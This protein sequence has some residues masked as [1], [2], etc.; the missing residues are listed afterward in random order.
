MKKINIIMSF[1][2]LFL[3]TAC[4]SNSTINSKDKNLS[5]TAQTFKVK[6][7]Q[8]VDMKIKNIETTESG[9]DENQ[10]IVVFTMKFKNNDSAVVGIGG[11]DF[12]IKADDKIYSIYG[13]GNNIGQEIQPEKIADG[14]LYF[15]LPTS[16]KKVILQYTPGDEILGKWNIKVPKAK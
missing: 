1:V 4:S 6:T 7:I 16:V 9:N 10:N 11:G 14:K 8:N 2:L 12:K 3:L 13:E 5:E 15:K